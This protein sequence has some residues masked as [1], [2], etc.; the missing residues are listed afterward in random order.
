[1]PYFCRSERGVADLE[2]FSFEVEG[3]WLP[4]LDVF[5]LPSPLLVMRSLS[6]KKLRP[7]VWMGGGGE[8]LRHSPSP[9]LMAWL[10]FFDWLR[11]EGSGLM[12]FWMLILL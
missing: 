7:L 6:A 1:M 2:D 8:S 9:G 10:G 3:G 11:S 4:V 12:G 5:Q